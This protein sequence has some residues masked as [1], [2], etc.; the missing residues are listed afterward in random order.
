MGYGFSRPTAALLEAGARKFE[1]ESEWFTAA[2]LA[3]LRLP[4]LPANKRSIN[5]RAREERWTTRATLDGEPLARHR[6]GRGGGFEFHL[7][8]LPPSARLELEKL[9]GSQPTAALLEAAN[10]DDRAATWGWLE[11]QPAKVRSEAE[12]CLAFITEITVLQS[13]GMTATAAVAEVSSRS[14]VGKSTLWAWRAAIKGVAAADRLPALAPRRKG[15]GSKTDIADVLW[16]QFK[17]DFL[18]PSAPTLTSCYARAAAYAAENGLSMASERTF[19]RRLEREIDPA[20]VK[21]RREGEEALRRSVPAQRRD[22]TQLHAME[23]VNIDGHKFDVFVQHPETGKPMRPVM[24]AIQDVRSSKVLAWRV[25]V[26]ETAASARLAFADLFKNWGIPVH[27]L[28]DNGRGFA[29]KWITGGNSTR[30]RFKVKEEE[31]TGLLTALGIQIHWALPY[32]GQSKP[33]ERAFRDLCDTISRHPAT[34]GAYTGNTPLAKPENYASRAMP[35]QAFV[36]HVAEGIAVHNARLGR[37]GRDY[38]G[39]SFDQVFA[40]SYATAPISKATPEQLRMAL[41]AAE[42][43]TVNRQ[44][45]E[46]GLYGNRYWSPEC[47]QYCGQK[48]TVRFDPDD[49]HGAVHLYAQD[50]GRFLCSAELLEDSGF[51][52]VEGAKSTA[53]RLSDYRRR[54]REGAQAEE[55]MLAE[56]LAAMQPRSNPPATPEPTVIRP[57][58]VRQRGNAAVA[59]VIETEIGEAAAQIRRSHNV[60]HLIGRSDD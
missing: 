57:V 17:S 8:L 48:V 10:R 19:R 6:A 50:D 12:R 44:T 32:R 9:R 45:G 29:S 24:V 28:L 55:L 46:I 41:L 22:V 11:R 2:E 36:A 16:T 18:R 42:M 30:Y 5:R 34:E 47:G 13:A 31:P 37:R 39:R 49:L 59:R 58:R 56:E 23:C 51:L 26:S 54:V 21:L 52:D 25:D 43:K 14:Q 33:I 15:G 20:I 38:A 60:L 4:G 7:S 53:K 35:W 40:D 27:C 1:V 3:D